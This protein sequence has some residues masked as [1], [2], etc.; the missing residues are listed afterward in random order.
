MVANVSGYMSGDSTHLPRPSERD[1]AQVLQVVLQSGRVG[2]HKVSVNS[3]SAAIHGEH[4]V[5]CTLHLVPYTL[6]LNL[7]L[8]IWNR[9]GVRVGL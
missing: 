1:L 4:V 7:N 3:T 6:Y 2:D 9:D 5:P 8:A